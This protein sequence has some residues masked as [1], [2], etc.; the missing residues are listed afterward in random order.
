MLTSPFDYDYLK[1]ASAKIRVQNVFCSFWP[2]WPLYSV[3]LCFF[4]KEHEIAWKPTN[5][6]S[7]CRDLLVERIRHAGAQLY[8]FHF[9]KPVSHPPLDPNQRALLRILEFN[10][11]RHA[12]CSWK[13]RPPAAFSSKTKKQSGLLR[14]SP[15]G[16]LLK[17]SCKQGAA[18]FLKFDGSGILGRENFRNF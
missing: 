4:N 17:F 15:N 13:I 11:S 7:N 6:G 8:R 2:F 12:G 9:Q 5:L 1:G 18:E 16:G 10:P 3:F 14:R